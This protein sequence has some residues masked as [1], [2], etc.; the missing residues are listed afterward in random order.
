MP[1]SNRPSQ[2]RRRSDDA[3]DRPLGG[4]Y[5]LIA[6][7]GSG[8]SARVFLAEDLSLS[9]RVAIKRLRVGLSDDP[10]FLRRFR[11]E[12]QAAAQLSHPNLLTVYDWGE[13]PA[14]IY[15][16]TEVLLGG[17]LLDMIKRG[18]R[19]SPS[20]G[21]LVAL[22]VAQG[23]HYAHGLGWVHRDIKPANLLFGEE[24]RLR[25]ADFGIARAVAE[26]SWTEPTGHLIGTARYAA[27]EQ[28]AADTVDGKADLYSLAL[29]IVEAVTGNVPLVADTG[30]ATLLLRQDRDV[31]GFE[32]LGALGEALAPAG[33][34]DP[35]D[36][37]EAA[38]LIEALTVA[39][40]SL[41][42]PDRLPLRSPLLRSSDDADGPPTNQP[43]PSPPIVD[44]DRR[45]HR[46]P[47]IE[48]IPERHARDL[49]R[50]RSDADAD[51][52]EPRIQARM[53][54]RPIEPAIE[55]LTES[56]ESWPAP[57]VTVIG[58]ADDARTWM[59]RAASPHAPSVGPDITVEESEPTADDGGR[60]DDD[61]DG[62]RWDDDANG[63]RWDDEDGGRWDDDDDGGRWG[64]A[65]EAGP[66]GG[67]ADRWST[68]DDADTV[69]DLID[70]DG[71]FDDDRIDLDGQFEDTDDQPSVS[72]DWPP[73]PMPVSDAPVADDWHDPGPPPRPAV[74]GRETRSANGPAPSARSWLDDSK[75][76]PPPLPLPSPSPAD[77]AI[78]DRD[79]WYA[80]MADVG[81]R[82]G[83]WPALSHDEPD[84]AVDSSWPS[85]G[86]DDA[87]GA[88]DSGFGPSA[89]AA[90]VAEA[91][92]DDVDD[93]R[94]GEDEHDR[95]GEVADEDR[96]GPDAWAVGTWSSGQWASEAWSQPFWDGDAS[97]EHP[98]D[99]DPVGAEVDVDQDTADEVDQAAV[100][101]WPAPVGPPSE[102]ADLWGRPAVG[103]YPETGVALTPETGIASPNGPAGP[104][105]F[106]VPAPAQAPYQPALAPP[107]SAEA[108]D[109]DLDDDE[110]W[111]ARLR[112]PP[113]E[114]G[115]PVRLT[116]LAGDD[117]PR[118]LP[119]P[120]PA[121]SLQAD[122]SAGDYPEWTAADLDLEERGGP[123]WLLPAM[124]L[125]ILVMMIGAILVVVLRDG[126]GAVDAGA[127]GAEGVVSA[128]VGGLA[129]D[130]EADAERNNWLL[131]TTRQESPDTVAGV[132]V[133]QDP[134]A[135]TTL[136]PGGRLSI[137]ISSGSP[138]PSSTTIT[139]AA[140]TGE[141]GTR[142]GDAGAG[143]SDEVEPAEAE[144]AEEGATVADA[145][146]E[147]APLPSFVGLTLEAALAQAD[148]L[149]LVVT[150]DTASSDRY[151]EG[152]VVDHNP[153]TGAMF[154]PGDD[155]TLVVS[156]GPRSTEVP[157]LAGST[158]D[159]ARARLAE[160][161]LEVGAI[162]GPSN[163]IV[164]ATAP[165][166]GEAVRRT[167]PI[168]LETEAA[169]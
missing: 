149:D 151:D 135:G 73:P 154:R 83:G 100:A 47:E 6:P 28:A 96:S 7:I 139:D 69:G 42:K 162:N 111:P 157:A 70:L 106:D 112:R 43:A 40:R 116:R 30:L 150:R 3:D 129:A 54:P 168:D 66:G 31:S 46:E 131:V 67:W 94:D 147:P 160:A 81:E 99:P 164:V 167:R 87:E 18:P 93:D 15:L 2:F 44:L 97:N 27:P 37:P 57:K 59:D 114:P 36:R 113:S 141:I 55:R 165:G 85:D 53:I 24:G 115:R 33:R 95:N 161:G 26:A 8:A 29:T 90:P 82:S 14:A 121:V 128:Y 124:V 108:A 105:I 136:E 153:P 50:V 119:R 123:R 78:A 91:A 163:G 104:S 84:A 127:S 77:R 155:I 120:V 71:P 23:L 1:D 32:P 166:A 5:R 76:D 133:A 52:G 25:I 45:E 156:T 11:A 109:A 158:V 62:G 74:A 98:A 10:R 86:W 38:E 35:R 92:A 130:A 103:S 142:S 13:D 20:Q 63:G 107:P 22:Q 21:L 144:P 41:P 126:D 64:G 9:R 118:P 49:A 137:V 89:W 58:R 12:A 4:R 68:D 72:P 61:A 17:S 117:E 48:L 140:A 101:D 102:P 125:V 148:E 159:E 80:P 138:S 34:A 39:A 51:D 19:L 169:S 152:F 16:V 65:D 56:V 79:E 75:L 134:A 88:V 146:A 122:A 143:G 60:W 132:V 110:R 145:A